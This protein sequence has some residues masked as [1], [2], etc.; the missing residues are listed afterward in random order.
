MAKV[1]VPKSDG[2]ILSKKYAVDYAVGDIAP[3]VFV[4][5]T[6]DQPKIIA[7]LK[8]LK[9][10]GYGNYWALYRPYHLCNL[11]T[12]IAVA[13][14]YLY[15]EATLNTLRVPVAE[16]IAMAKRDLRPGDKID[17]LGGFTVYGCIETT[18]VAKVE[19]CVP[20]GII[21]GATVR[22]NIERGQPIRFEDVELD[23]NQTVYLLRKLQDKMVGAAP[24]N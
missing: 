3:G 16:T 7:D 5:I 2:G 18:E 12:P 4:V 10:N 9:L 20:L 23:E 11:E 1:F 22:K 6:T 15:R 8:Y 21:V 24:K 19:G 13:R 17:A 14:A